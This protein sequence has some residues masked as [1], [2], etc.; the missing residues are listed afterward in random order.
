[1]PVRS[2]TA[3]LAT[4]AAL[5]VGSTVLNAC[6]ASS[7]PVAYVPL[8]KANFSSSMVAAVKG[9][10]SFHEVTTSE[11]KTASVEFDAHGGVLV[12][13][14][15]QQ[16]AAS[17]GSPAGTIVAILIGNDLYA[18]KT[19]GKTG[20]KWVKVQASDANL[21]TAT[22]GVS[23]SNPAEVISDLT[24]G[25]TSFEYMGATDIDGA[26]VEQYQLTLTAAAM[27][28]GVGST[29]LGANAPVTEAVYLNKDNTLRRLIVMTPLGNVTV[30]F[31]DWGKP[32]GITAPPAS[33]IMPAKK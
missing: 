18:R 3:S 22:G 8:T 15:T 14:I 21:A 24:K 27:G 11:G 32:L 16:V 2:K 17:K 20:N 31:T 23:K 13:R 12:E 26:P 29:D 28:Q 30:D 19:P 25:M 5:A 4:I 7:K 10:N 6:G 9:K 33:D 1:M